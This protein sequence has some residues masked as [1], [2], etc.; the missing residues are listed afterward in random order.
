MPRIDTGYPS[1]RGTMQRELLVWVTE[2]P[3][4]GRQRRA[5]A[6][7]DDDVAFDFP[8]QQEGRAIWGLPAAFPC[9]RPLC[10]ICGAR[11]CVRLDLRG[12]WSCGAE[13]V[14]GE[15][16]SSTWRCVSRETSSRPSATLGH[17]TAPP[18]FRGHFA[19]ERRQAY[20]ISA[21]S[22]LSLTGP[23]TDGRSW[24]M[25]DN[26]HGAS[27]FCGTAQGHTKAATYCCQLIPQYLASL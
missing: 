6:C 16:V 22:S 18:L 26:A 15:V 25:T 2:R 5:V 12:A 11:R 24:L 8:D 19:R 7:P 3:S 9:G 27:R 17:D 23:F 1:P 21:G 14:P 4:I 13:T 20:T 10:G